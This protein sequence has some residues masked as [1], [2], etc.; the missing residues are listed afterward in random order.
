MFANR[1]VGVLLWIVAV[2]V[3]DIPGLVAE[4]KLLRS[5]LAAIGVDTSREGSTLYTA[6]LFEVAIAS[7]ANNTDL[8][9]VFA[10]WLKCPPD[11]TT[12]VALAGAKAEE[13]PGLESSELEGALSAAIAEATSVLA[14]PRSR[15]PSPTFNASALVLSNGYWRDEAGTPCF[16]TGFNSV[17][18]ASITAGQN[19]SQ[20]AY[21]SALRTLASAY[22]GACWPTGRFPPMSSRTSLRRLLR[23]WRAATRSRCSL[24]MRRPQGGP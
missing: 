14:S 4:L 8:P 6:A 17:P 18:P 15:L 5:Q 7:D 13:L 23:R 22:T 9:A 16:A 12:C 10:A 24:T 21:S 2:A 19:G 1:A 20:V 11:N 3:A